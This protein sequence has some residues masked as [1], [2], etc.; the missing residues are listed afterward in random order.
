M[1]YSSENRLRR[2]NSCTALRP[3]PLRSEGDLTASFRQ[4][5]V[6]RL[7]FREHA[8]TDG[9]PEVLPP[10][11]NSVPGTASAAAAGVVAGVGPLVTPPSTPTSCLGSD[12]SLRVS[13]ILKR[14]N[15]HRERRLSDSRAQDAA[16]D[17]P[18]VSRKLASWYAHS[19]VTQLPF[20]SPCNPLARPSLALPSSP[21]SQTR[22][23]QS[24]PPK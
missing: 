7:S 15:S 4:P 16:H 13:T 14:W 11:A 5:R 24:R 19:P 6:R 23:D 20:L 1:K 8:R 2:R 10:R 17:T 21:S 18:P 22:H 9:A 3:R 12:P